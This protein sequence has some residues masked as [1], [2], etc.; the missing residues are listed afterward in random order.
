MEL[1][2]SNIGEAGVVTEQWW[3][4][5]GGD[6][7]YDGGADPLIR[8]YYDGVGSKP[9]IEFRLFMAHGMG[10]IVCGDDYAAQKNCVDP[11]VT[12]SDAVSRDFFFFVV[13]VFFFTIYI[14]LMNRL[15]KLD[16]L[17][18]RTVAL[19]LPVFDISCSHLLMRALLLFFTFLSFSSEM[20]ASLHSVAGK[21]E[22]L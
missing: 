16:T 5:F 14:S 19:L 18:A 10:P 20:I 6:H 17:V 9:S 8:I 21:P 15:C 3:S 1:F 7:R 2:S 22:R 13:E 4:I 11:A 12:A